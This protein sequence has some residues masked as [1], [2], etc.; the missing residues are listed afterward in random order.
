MYRREALSGAYSATAYEAS[1]YLRSILMGLLRG[2]IFSPFVYWCVG[3]PSLCAR[4]SLPLNERTLGLSW[5]LQA[6]WPVSD[7]GRLLL[8]L[9][10]DRRRRHA[11]VGAR[12][13]RYRL[14]QRAANGPNRLCRHRYARAGPRS[15]C[16][17]A[18]V[19]GTSVRWW[20]ERAFAR[21]GHERALVA[22]T[23]VRLRHIL[24]DCAYPASGV[25]VPCTSL[26]IPRIPPRV[27]ASHAHP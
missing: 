23:S 1:W 25:G 4:R 9:P 11:R 18:L 24:P 16:E 20:Q 3:A 7:R 8:L 10:H 19:A 13:L 2:L 5:R 26:P 27:R 14:L 17:H 21:G 22:G 6:G 12:P 15:G